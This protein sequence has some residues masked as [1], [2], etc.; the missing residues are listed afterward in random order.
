MA[1]SS[2]AQEEAIKTAEVIFRY[3][4]ESYLETS[5]PAA[6]AT[7]PKVP[8]KPVARTTSFLASA[9]FFQRPTTATSATTIS[10]CTPQE[11][12]A[13]ELDRY[14]RFEAAPLELAEEVLLNPLLWWKVCLIS[15][16]IT[17]EFLGLPLGPCY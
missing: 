14:F 1:E 17:H 2:V 7:A 12:L 13:D 4:A 5:L 16:I 10:K 6:V 15:F 9:Y 8:A 3:V 11:E